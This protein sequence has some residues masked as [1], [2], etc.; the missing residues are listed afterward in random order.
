MEDA[1]EVA[2]DLLLEKLVANQHSKLRFLLVHLDV[3][4][5][6][7]LLEAV[8]AVFDVWR[9]WNFDLLYWHKVGLVVNR[10]EVAVRDEVLFQTVD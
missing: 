3:E 10:D 2:F 7:L 8:L 4:Y 9:V 6:H 5:L 1:K